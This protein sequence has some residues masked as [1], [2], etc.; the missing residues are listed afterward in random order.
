MFS[1]EYNKKKKKGQEAGLDKYRNTK[2]KIKQLQ[3]EHVLPNISGSVLEIF[4]GEG[5]LSKFY[6]KHA[7][8]V[9]EMKKD[10]H[11]DAYD[12]SNML[13]AM[14]KKFDVI[15]IDGYG[16]PD[17]LLHA[18]FD[19]LNDNGLLIFT[20]PIINSSPISRVKEMNFVDSWGSLRPDSGDIVG[21]VTN[22]ARKY[23]WMIPSCLDYRRI[24]FIWRYVF[25][26]KKI[27]PNDMMGYI[28]GDNSL[29]INDNKT[30]GKRRPNTIWTEEMNDIVL[31]N[32]PLVAAKQLGLSSAVVYK[33][34]RHLLSIS[35]ASKSKNSIKVNTNT[36]TRG[37]N[38]RRVYTKKMNNLILSSKPIADI[39]AELGKTKGSIY[40][41]RTRLLQKQ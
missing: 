32:T 36:K 15:D 27:N 13:R 1:K 23:Q 33:W 6:N 2:A 24:G 3:L 28:K 9:F 11:G 41:Q 30:K 18:S 29:D 31:N 38:R 25:Q 12:F 5:N 14:K 10:I 35:P 26:C 17:K 8:S 20:F 22:L 4:S 39:A 16:F 19:M 40:Q 34:R 21:T 7:D 37:G